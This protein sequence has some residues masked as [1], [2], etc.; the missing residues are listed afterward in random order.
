ML[1]ITVETEAAIVVFRLDG[2]LAGPEVRELARNWRTAALEQP[3]QRVL[4]DLAGVTSVDVL[5]KAFL[6]QVYQ[7]GHKLVGGV[8]TKAIV[9]E[10][11][12]EGRPTVARN[13]GGTVQPL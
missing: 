8:T 1:M 6:A 13:S 5:G 4:F 10:I 7:R 12:G 3:H 11:M 9:E 2:R